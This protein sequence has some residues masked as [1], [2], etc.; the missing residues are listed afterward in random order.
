M[1]RTGGRALRFRDEIAKLE[2]DVVAL[3]MMVLARA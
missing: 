3:E 1:T 2:V